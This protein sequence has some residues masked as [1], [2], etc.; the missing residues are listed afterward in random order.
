MNDSVSTRLINS[1]AFCT[2]FVRVC[3][4]F[5]SEST[6]LFMG[7]AGLKS[8]MGEAEFRPFTCIGSTNNYIVIKTQQ[9]R[10]RN[11]RYAE[12]I[13]KLLIVSHRG[14]RM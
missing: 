3:A 8:E 13:S 10:P 2:M 12:F 4:R 14:E 11:C 9:E 6:V 7:V 5:L 1:D